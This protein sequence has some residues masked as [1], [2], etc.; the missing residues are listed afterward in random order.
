MIGSPAEDFASPGDGLSVPDPKL[1]AQFAEHRRA[2]AAQRFV[3][4]DPDLVAAGADM[5]EGGN[6]V[7]EPIV[8]SAL[9][10]PLEQILKTGKSDRP[11]QCAEFVV[12]DVGH[13]AARKIVLAVLLE[14]AKVLLQ[15]RG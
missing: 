1:A 8:Q 14:K 15:Q 12:A 5:F 2:I 7:C 10:P 3:G 9:I 13:V 4:H 11:V 6:P